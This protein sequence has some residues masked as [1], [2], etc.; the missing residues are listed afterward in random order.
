MTARDRDAP[1]E[2][3]FAFANDDGVELA[4]TLTLPADEPRAWAVFAHCFTCGKDIP[5]AARLAA[6]LARRGVAVLRFDFTGLG[7]SGGDFGRGGFSADVAD[8]QAAAGALGDEHAA[9]ALLVGHSLGGTAALAAAGR[10]DGVRGVA[11]IGAP[12]APDH[13]RRVFADARDEIEEEGEA[14]VS[15]A[16]RTFTVARSFLED[17]EEHDVPARL[18]ELDA[19]VMV[20]HSPRDEVTGIDEAR[21]IFEAARHPKSFVSLDPADHLLRREADTDFA[22][23]VLAAW[24]TRLTS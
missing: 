9:P 7:G 12:A 23:A 10:I 6:G 15:I 8:L 3:P 13:L 21:K 20:M 14:Q 2:Q 16:G 24:T 18:A 22:A 4:G 19:A 1:A 5:A 11:T 17:L